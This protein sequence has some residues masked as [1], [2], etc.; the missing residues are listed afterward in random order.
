MEEEKKIE[1]EVTT[2]K[3]E[4]SKKKG[5]SKK[6][7]TEIEKFISEDEDKKEISDDA[8]K[9]KDSK[10]KFDFKNKKFLFVLAFII[11][12]FLIIFFV[13]R[14]SKTSDEITKVERVLSEQ[15]YSVNC[16]DTKCNNLAAYSGDV[17]KEITV[18]L[19]KS[20]GTQVA[21]YTEKNDAEAKVSKAPVA[22]GDNWF[23]FKKTNNETKKD[24]GYSI[25]NKH[26]EEIYNTENKLSI[27]NDNLV[28]MTDPDKGIDGY[29]ILSS[30]GKVLFSNVN[31]IETYDNDSIISAEIKGTKQILDK[32]GSV[33]LNNYYVSREVIDED[34]KVLY[35]LVKDSKNNAYNYY[36][37]SD[38][39]IVGDSF[40][41]YV[42]NNDRTLSV[43]KKENNK[44]VKYKVSLDGDQELVGNEV[45]QSEIVSELKKSIDQ[46][47][48]SIY[49]TSVYDKDQKYVLVDDL[50]ENSFGVYE[51]K[52]KKYTKLY[53]YKEGTNSYTSVYELNETDSKDNYYLQLSCST[54]SCDKA[55]FYVYDIANAKVEYSLDDE[56][57]SISNYY[58]YEDG[59]KVIKYSYAS[60]NEKYRGKYVLINKDGNEVT[61]STNKISIIDKKQ[62]IGTDSNSS[63]II[64]S[65][66]SNKVLNDDDNLAAKITVSGKKYYKYTTKDKIIL[67]DETGKEVINTSSKNDL[68]YSDMM[69]IYIEDKT[70]NM[71]NG[72]TGKLNTY[73]LGDNEKMNDASGELI[74]PYRGAL[75]IN[76]SQD[77]K[78]KVVNSSGNTI[79]T[80]DNVE[81]DSVTHTSDNNVLIISKKFNDN[82]TLYG[83]YIAK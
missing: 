60:T 18:T 56:A 32:E 23:I 67:I 83:A 76:N 19:V 4:S 25:A 70:V 40:Q 68:M 36:S 5:T 2:E 37:V 52:S 24:A 75:F 66:A 47:K 30:S 72:K 74:P 3:V 31:D 48:Y 1:E 27:I 35:L 53:S 57:L 82:K 44:V 22:L 14:N 77:K 51:I 17:A 16:L 39:K 11:F 33:L 13:F 78:I 43:T 6:K 79:K 58:Q 12:V 46:S 9:D 62:L 42:I 80:M 15:Y 21:K 71:M 63:L 10:K 20:N 65:A 26:G 41:N 54:Y 61:V 49:S 34:G 38:K 50:N 7:K 8:F 28:L 55:L 69:I 81:I 59:Y 64:Y 29:S 73:K 45:T